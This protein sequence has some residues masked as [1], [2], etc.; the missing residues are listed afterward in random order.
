[1]ARILRMVVVSSNETNKPNTLRKMLERG[2]GSGVPLSILGGPPRWLGRGNP[3][4]PQ[5]GEGCRTWRNGA[6][7]GLT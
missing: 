5:P 7:H 2:G 1:M 3:G 6:G 4:R